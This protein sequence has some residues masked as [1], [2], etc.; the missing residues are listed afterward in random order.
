MTKRILH[1]IPSTALG[2]TSSFIMN[3]YRNIDRKKM[4]FDFVAFNK[5]E[6][7]DEIID[8]GGHIFY[9]EWIKKQGIISYIRNLRNLIKDEGPFHA[10]HAHQSYKAVFSLIPARL[11]GINNR[12]AH[13]HAISPE[14]KWHN[15][16]LPFLKRLTLRNS[17]TLLACSH[18]AGEKIY[19]KDNFIVLPNNIDSKKF[20]NTT[21][22]DRMS[23]R[24]ELNIPE[25]I[26]L[27]G[28]VG[29]FSEV[30]NHKFIVD[31]AKELKNKDKEFKILLV[32]EGPLREEIINDINNKELNNNFIILK[33][34][35]DINKIMKSLDIFIC[36]S[37]FESFS[38]VLLEAQVTGVP[39]IASS[40]IPKDVDLNLGLLKYENI[41]NTET[42]WAKEIINIKTHPNIKKEEIRKRVIEKGF[43]TNSIIEKL[44]SVY[45]I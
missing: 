31:I 33:P 21:I 5:G 43:D 23:I 37:L 30:K 8:M 17:T 14:T 38:I 41:N 6:L 28:H 44:I 22:R 40:N 2:G 10:I 1:I 9:F 36:P 18:I 7:H 11:E 29:R 12:I 27:I 20:L 25:D 39:S 24:R 15:I 19:G 34:R 4:Q 3:I 32:G 13:T 42:K 26:L 45:K 35:D 16:L